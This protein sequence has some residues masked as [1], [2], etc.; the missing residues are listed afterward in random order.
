MT[1]AIIK[2]DRNTIIANIRSSNI[3]IA[4]TVKVGGYR[5]KRQVSVK[6]FVVSANV[7]GAELAAAV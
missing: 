2:A 6:K 3:Q 7:A 1:A 5:A 4:I